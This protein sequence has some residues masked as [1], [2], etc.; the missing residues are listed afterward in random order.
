MQSNS[1]ALPA[2][3]MKAKR[4][5]HQR[6][7]KSTNFDKDFINKS[8]NSNVIKNIAEAINENDLVG[9]LLLHEAQNTII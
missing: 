4:R 3:I 9:L 1:K 6:Y 5:N 7:M 8:F 2:A